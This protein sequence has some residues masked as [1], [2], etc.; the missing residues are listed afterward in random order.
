[1]FF[2]LSLIGLFLFLQMML[3][4]IEPAPSIADKTASVTL[5]VESQAPPTDHDCPA[6]GCRCRPF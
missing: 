5:D 3:L 4:A 6:N 1:M 2:R